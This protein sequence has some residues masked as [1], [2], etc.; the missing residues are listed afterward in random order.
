[1]SVAAI[2]LTLLPVVNQLTRGQCASRHRQSAGLAVAGGGFA[3]GGGAAA[4][5]NVEL[6]ISPP[7]PVD[8]LP[9]A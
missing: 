7:F 3:G 9:G 4:D 1:V 8:R 5:R 2:L 6:L